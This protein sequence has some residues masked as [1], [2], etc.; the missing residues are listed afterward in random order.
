MTGMLVCS[1]IYFT[2]ALEPLGMTRSMQSSSVSISET[3]ARVSSNCSH[4]SGR[5]A[6]TEASKTVVARI[7][8]VFK[9]SLPP[10]MSTAFPL[11]RQRLEICTSASGRDSNTTPITPM[12]QETR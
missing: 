2:K 6:A 12:G 5:P 4:P 7:R 1:M 9:A 11:F 3:S 10:F 8:L